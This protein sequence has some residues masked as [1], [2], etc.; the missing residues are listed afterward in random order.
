M[1]KIIL[2]KEFGFMEK[3]RDINLLILLRTI[4]SFIYDNIVIS[5]VSHIRMVR[6]VEKWEFIIIQGMMDS[7]GY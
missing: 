7:N 5:E 3:Y 4:D 6:S 2:S 1:K